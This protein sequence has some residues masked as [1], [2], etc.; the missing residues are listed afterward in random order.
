M[1]AESNSKY[2]YCSGELPGNVQEAVNRMSQGQAN[3]YNAMHELLCSYK[4]RYGIGEK[5]CLKMS[6]ESGC[7]V[8]SIENTIGQGGSKKA[9]LFTDGRVA[10][11]P[12]MDVDHFVRTAHWWSETVKNEASMVPFLE[13]IGVLALNR[14]EA[15]IVVPSKNSEGI[16][17]ELPILLSDSFEQYASRGWFVFDMKNPHKN[18]ISDK[19]KW[20]LELKSWENT[21][22]PLLT[23]LWKLVSNDMI[24]EL[25]SQNLVLIN[26]DQDSFS[27]R[28]FGYDFGGKY[29]SVRASENYVTTIEWDHNTCVAV[30]KLAR[31][32]VQNF[33][34]ERIYDQVDHMEVNDIADKIAEHFSSCD[35][36]KTEVFGIHNSG[37][38]EL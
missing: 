8:V 1:S 29:G 37:S 23:D 21:I 10:M 28:Y 14:K 12:N 34:A 15:Y 27:L 2:P 31:A 3:S 9:V 13:D 25:D 19:E 30:S 22:T 20:S 5:F 11:F 33:V 16:S 6:S 35:F 4:N 18:I 24:P 17:Y 26:T 38:D 7:E 32:I 36:I